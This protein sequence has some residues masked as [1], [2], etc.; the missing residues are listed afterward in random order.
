MNQ[1]RTEIRDID[2]IFPYH[3]N[4]K[5]HDKTQVERI[6]KSI[7]D[8]GFDQHIVIDRDGVIIKGHGRREAALS[9]GL[10][11]VPV[12]VRDDLTD[13]EVRAARL[14]DN[15]V[16]V[17]DLDADL[18]QQELASLNFDLEGIFDRKELDFMAADMAEMNIDSIV[19]DLESAVEEQA[20]ETAGKIAETDL[21]MVRIDKVLGFKEIQG[22]DERAIARFMAVAEDETGEEG[23]EAFV[24]YIKQLMAA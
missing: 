11:Q 8:F 1:I 4:A 10:K 5:I 13:D 9:L 12:I 18:L 20:E 6:A 17:G 21:R 24:G 7:K 22:K 2:Q 23:A 19:L 16:A 14:A 3:L 15:R